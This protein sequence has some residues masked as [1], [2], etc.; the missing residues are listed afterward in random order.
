MRAVLSN[1]VYRCYVGKC[2]TSFPGIVVQISSNSEDSTPFE[3]CVIDTQLE[4][5]DEVRG[6]GRA[7]Q[8]APRSG[9]S[10]IYINK[11]RT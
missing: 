9:A 5:K 11:W 10:P 7:I 6:A 3:R 1:T 4:D 2:I 8:P